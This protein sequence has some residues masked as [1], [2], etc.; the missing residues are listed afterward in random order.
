MRSS[1]SLGEITAPILVFGGPYSNLAATKAI[2]A[3][4]ERLTIPPER[5]ICTGDVI[6][7]CA[8]PVATTDLIRTWGISVVMGNCEESLAE[9]SPDCGCGFEE[10]S[11]CSLLS[12]GWYNYANQVVTL[13]QRRWMS[14][15]PRNL[16]F[17]LNGL[18]FL[19]I[20]GGVERINE[21]IFRSTSDE[22][23]VQQLEKSGVDVIIGGHCGIPFG[24]AL[25]NGH[26]L[27]AGVIGMP[28]NDATPDGWYMLLSPARDHVEVTWHRLR[29]PA[30]HS[31][32]AMLKAGLNNEYADALTTGLWPSTDVLPDSEKESTAK[33]IVLEGYDLS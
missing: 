6:A 14:E 2:Q 17:S 15:L 16:S 13:S 12:V 32:Q 8:D 21:F 31:R 11:S 23:K 22:V 5:V 27:N 29:Y 3:E 25:R 18:K 19:V 24:Q 10:G 33:T 26:W 1:I 4:A 9:N 30:A 20:H 28:A 7:Y